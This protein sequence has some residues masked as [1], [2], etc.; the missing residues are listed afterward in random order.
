[1]TELTNSIRDLNPGEVPY[2]SERKL[3]SY[4]TSFLKDRI[5]RRELLKVGGLSGLSLSAL[6][7]LAC[8]PAAPVLTPTKGPVAVAPTPTTLLAAPT[9][10]TPPAPTPTPKPVG[11]SLSD[12]AA[13]AK[14]ITEYSYDFKTTVAGQTITGKSYMKRDKMRQ[15]VTAPM[16]MVMLADFSKKTAYMLMPDAKIATKMDLSG[17]ESTER[18]G[19]R[20]SGL[21]SDAKFV[22]TETIGGKPAAVFEFTSEGNPAKIWIWTERGVPLKFEMT[23][24]GQKAVMEFSN[25]QFGPLADSLFEVPAGWQIVEMPTMPGVPTVPGR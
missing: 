15:E 13:K 19:E 20:V 12:L 7:A 1:M 6:W 14:A 18:P 10:T 21:P 4:L 2:E 17:V 24:A 3:R 25:Y 16:P 11:V 23:S 9:P 22:G 8:Q 5:T